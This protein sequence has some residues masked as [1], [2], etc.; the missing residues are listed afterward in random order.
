MF[1]RYCSTRAFVTCLLIIKRVQ[2]D[3]FL[4][5]PHDI[6]IG[7]RRVQ[8]IEKEISAY[9]CSSIFHRLIILT[10]HSLC[11]GIKFLFLS[12]NFI[13]ISISD[14]DLPSLALHLLP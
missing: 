7:F 14:S 12:N 13:P 6:T 5:I 1:T 11:P 3:N 8:R 10:D 2:T 4:S 9:S